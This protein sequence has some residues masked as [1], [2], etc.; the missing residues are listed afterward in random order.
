MED[1][2]GVRVG[3]AALA[4]VAC[5]AGSIACSGSSAD[6]Q[7]GA[8]SGASSTVPTGPAAPFPAPSPLPDGFNLDGGPAF[9]GDPATFDSGIPSAP[10]DDPPFDPNVRTMWAVDG[11]NQLVRF[12]ADA[13]GTVTARALTGLAAGERVMGID[14]RPAD[15]NL[16][17][18][19]STSRVYVV[20]R[21]T[22]VATA[23]GAKAFA[24]ELAGIAFGLA[25]NPVADELRVHS[26]YDQ[27]LRLDPITG[28]A[29]SDGMLAFAKGEVNE[30]QSPNLVACAYTNS[31]AGA[32][33][34]TVLFAIDSTRNLLTSLA[35]P[36]DGQVST[37]GDLGVDVSDVAGFDIWGGSPSK[38]LQAYAL[39]MTDPTTTGLYTIDLGSGAASLVGAIGTTTALR[40]LAVEP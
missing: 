37:I 36:N 10:P 31:A 32:P 12:T 29:T 9:D 19:G 27:N 7:D 3:L 40:G 4:F 39:L 11:A 17:A 8:D 23:V 6:G 25:V 16:Y 18:I 22:G 20:D 38:P 14:F 28:T 24:P 30:G 2:V 34:T 5:V 35:N 21:K 26:D 15:G 33:L 13:P 1:G